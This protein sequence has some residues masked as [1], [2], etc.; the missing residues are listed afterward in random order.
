MIYNKK[1]FPKFTKVNESGPSCPWSCCS[2]SDS[3]F[4]NPQ[5]AIVPVEA[6]ATYW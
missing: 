1:Y 5:R 4:F 2:A 6:E 3:A